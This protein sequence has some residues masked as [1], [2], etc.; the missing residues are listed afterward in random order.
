MGFSISSV[1]TCLGLLSFFGRYDFLLIRC[2]HILRFSMNIFLVQ[3]CTL[4]CINEYATVHIIIKFISLW[5]LDCSG[6]ETSVRGLNQNHIE[7]LYRTCVK[8]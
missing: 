4:H 2:Y 6:P 5:I 8:N 1:S 7:G 3:M